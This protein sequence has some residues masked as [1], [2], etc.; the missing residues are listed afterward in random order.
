ML[1]KAMALGC[2]LLGVM[3]GPAAAATIDVTTTADVIANDGQCSLREA[4]TAANT[5]TASGSA[6][7]ECQAGTPG[8]NQ[9][10]LGSGTYRLSSGELDVTS[11]ITLIGQGPSVTTI[12]A[13]SQSRVL[14]VA[15]G[16]SLT[17]DDV[18]L[19]GGHAPDGADATSNSLAGSGADGGA[20][21]NAGSLSLDDVALIG[22]HAGNGG[23]GS[24]SYGSYP[25]QQGDG[26]S[27][28]G[29]E[30]TGAALSIFDST[31]ADNAAGNGGNGGIFYN[32]FPV[33]DDGGSEGGID[34]TVGAVTITGSTISGNRANDAGNPSGGYAVAGSNAGLYVATA[35]PLTLTNDTIANNTGGDAPAV[36]VG[37]SSSA[38]TIS[39]L[40]IAGNTAANCCDFSTDAPIRDS[41]LDARCYPGQIGGA[42]NVSLAGGGCPGKQVPASR[43]DL[44]PLQNNGGPTETMLPE[45]G[46]ALIDEVPSRGAGCLATD[47]RGV[48]R[49]QGRACDAGAVEVRAPVVGLHSS[50]RTLGRVRLGRTRRKTLRLTYVSGEDLLAVGKVR[51]TGHNSRDFRIVANRCRGR[52]LNPTSSCTLVITFRPTKAGR[53]MAKLTIMVAA[54]GRPRTVSLVGT[55]FG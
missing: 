53:R 19:T 2:V 46:S 52:S 55:G 10:V 14:D 48:P 17:V 8:G 18:T 47:Q 43:F 1:A 34:A 26:G 38:T 35:A 15:S 32:H 6:P 54:P 40:T 27:G 21:D 49:P 36:G 33:A 41:A 45:T 23:N 7:G 20:I 29:I 13:E 16:A 50:R 22:N 9:I 11:P 31:I 5:D 12:N 28:G 39:Q 25:Q 44:G 24:P 4:V 51:I 42:H 3:A 37:S 30:S